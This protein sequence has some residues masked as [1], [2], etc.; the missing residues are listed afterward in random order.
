MV[1]ALPSNDALERVKAANRLGVQLYLDEYTYHLMFEALDRVISAR[2]GR[3]AELR[4]ICH[5][6]MPIRK[7]KLLP[8]RFPWLNP[9]QEAAV[10]EVLCA[11]D[12]AVVHGPP[13]TG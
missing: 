11:K 1:I 12:V 3:L 4:D 13:G 6:D 10:N 2:N 7:Y 5:T 9:S 8:V